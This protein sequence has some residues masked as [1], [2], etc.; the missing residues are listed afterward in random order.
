MPKT[1]QDKERD[2]AFRQERANQLKRYRAAQRAALGD[3]R[4]LLEDAR[5]RI[6]T[7]MAATPSDFQSW[8]LPNIQQSI[9]QALGEIGADLGNRGAGHLAAAHRI[10]VDLVDE[11]LKAGGIRILGVLPEVDLRQL[12]AMRTFLVDRMKDVTAEVATKVKRQIGLVMIGALSPA[13]A[14]TGISGMVL[15][16]RSRAI[17]ILRTEM[18]RAFSV[19]TQERQTQAAEHLPGLKKQW[20]RSGKVHSR[21][22]HDVADGQIVDVDK[23][24]VIGGVELMYPRDPKAPAKETV[25]CGCVQLPIMEHWD[26]R[27]PG[28]TPFTDEEVFK[29]PIK[30]DLARE[31]NPQVRHANIETLERLS[32]PA[33][34]RQIADDMAGEDFA[35]FVARTGGPTEHRAVAVAPDDLAEAMGV[36]ARAVRLSSYTVVKQRERRRGQGFT[37]ADYR[38]TQEIIDRGMLVQEN[39]T[40]VMAFR[41]FGDEVW[42]AVLKRTGAGD[43]LYL[44]S[45][46]RSNQAQRRRALTKH[47][48]IREE[49]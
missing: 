10:G 1:P 26:V 33:A 22:A 23:P 20:R 29:S 12:M 21:I 43:E 30:R 17:T 16:G 41:T 37:A 3:V 32:V 19:A 4:S 8:Q 47:Q 31:L 24:F 6:K 34:R 35:A 5:A 39:D 25:N 27:Q 15:G 46:H 11:P 9:D 7:E 13:D 48:K 44:Q 42:K 2:K 38:R 49:K 40:H 28:R 14:T 36:Q 45:L 18:G